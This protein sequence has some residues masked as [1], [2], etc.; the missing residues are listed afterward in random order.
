[1]NAG[2]LLEIG[3]EE[4]PAAEIP[5]LMQQVHSKAA[6]LLKDHRLVYDRIKVLSTPRRL[7]LICYNLSEIQSVM[8][9]EIKGPPVAVAFDA[10]NNPTAAATG[11]ATSHGKRVSD[12]LRQKMGGKEYLVLHRA[13]PQ[14]ATSVVLTSLLPELIVSIRAGKSMRWDSSGLEFVRPIRWIVCLYGNAIIPFTVGRDGLASSNCTRGHRFA[15]DIKLSSVDEYE[16]RLAEQLV[17]VDPQMRYQ[18]VQKAIAA[19]EE[20]EGVTSIANDELIAHIVHSTEYPTAILGKF[21]VEFLSLPREV[22]STTLYEEGKFITFTCGDKFSTYFLGFRNGPEESYGIVKA[23]YERAV[24]AR[25]RDSQFFFAEDTKRT[26]AE[27]TYQ[28]RA[29]IYEERIGSLWE[30]VA[31]I[32]RLAGEI[33]QR[34]KQPNLDDIDRAAFLCK[35]DL[36]TKMVREFPVL[37]GTMGKIYARCAGEKES[38]ACAIED[39]YRPRFKGDALPVNE[40]SV[41]LSLADKLDTVVCA[42]SIGEEPTGSRDPYGIRRQA[43]GMIRLILEQEIDINLFVLLTNLN[44]LYASITDQRGLDGVLRFLSDRLEQILLHEYGLTY[45]VV[46]CILAESNMAGSVMN[47]GNF[48]RILAKGRALVNA[49]NSEGFD[50]LVIAFARVRNITK[51][52]KTRQFDPQLFIEAEE[53]ELWREYLKAAGQIKRLTE[54]KDYCGVI[55]YLI[56]LRGPIDRFFDKVLV[57]TDDKTQ[58]SNRLAFL[59]NL[60]DLFFNIGD[61]STITVDTNS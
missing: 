35:S 10:H 38:V 8:T 12:L 33:A 28:L 19:V 24:Q 16:A 23:G 46:N 39:Q 4:M 2:L 3:I 1:M 26:L 14:L 43:N 45:D 53:K 31:R 22:I 44:E 13:L 6:V 15:N 42:I 40:I 34:N 61:L 51:G 54:E 60:S 11:F 5:D 57:M 58:R 21:P 9:E 56:G 7:S 37:Q 29:V 18:R 59:T 47:Q 50:S 17:I 55:G 48:Y 32:R 36:V 49:R 52:Y 27:W 41:V 30:K 25:L 20:R